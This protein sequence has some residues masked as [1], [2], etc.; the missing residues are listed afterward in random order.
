MDIPHFMYLL[1]KTLP[2]QILNL[3]LDPKSNMY[4]IKEWKQYHLTYASNQNTLPD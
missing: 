1:G 2:E 3:R 4:P